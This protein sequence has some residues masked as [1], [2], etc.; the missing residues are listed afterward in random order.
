VIWKRLRMRAPRLKT[1]KA[2]CAGYWSAFG[3]RVCGA[4][5]TEGVRAGTDPLEDEM[6]NGCPAD[7]R[8]YRFCAA[9]ICPLADDG[10][11]WFPNEAVC[12]RTDAPKWVERQK[13]IARRSKGSVELSFT[14]ADLM[15]IA[16]GAGAERL[17][18]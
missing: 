14:R 4:R 6:K 8:H 1:R 15:R 9:P 17:D 13:E 16:G 3:V 7:C 2:S 18:D 12:R 11:A 10:A 5:G